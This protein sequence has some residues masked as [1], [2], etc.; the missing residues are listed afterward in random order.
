M[1]TLSDDVELP[2]L[3]SYRAYRGNTAVGPLFDPQVNDVPCYAEDKRRLVRALSGSQVVAESTIWCDLL[4]VDALPPESEV[5]VNGRTRTVLV[6][7]RLTYT[8]E[9]PNHSE[10]ALR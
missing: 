8:D 6:H 5:D 1:T 9:T 7:S 3:F 10:I 4:A 2:H